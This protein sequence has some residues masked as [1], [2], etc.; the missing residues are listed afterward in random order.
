M[1]KKTEPQRR[2]QK[3]RDIFTVFSMASVCIVGGVAF[4]RKFPLAS[5]STGKVWVPTIK[6]GS[7]LP[8]FSGYDWSSHPQ[9]LVLAL[10]VGCA[11]CEASMDFY[12]RLIAYEKSHTIP[13]HVIAVFPDSEKEV[14]K[15]VGSA[16]S[17][18]PIFTLIDLRVLDVGVTPTILLVGSNRVIKHI[19]RGRLSPFQEEIVLGFISTQ[20]A[21]TS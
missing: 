18:C 3:R 12:E 4:M 16:M 21:G 13:T 20:N 1:D 17:G 15:E 6:E 10:R 14:Q 7:F 2:G 8:A 11:F 9:T 19:W 5:R